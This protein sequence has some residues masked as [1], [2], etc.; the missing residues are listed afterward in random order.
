MDLRRHVG[1]AERHRLM[2]EDRFAE[3]LTL[4]RVI[5]RAFEGGARH[6]YRLRRDADAPAL[7]IGQRDLVALAFRAQP[8]RGRDAH[9]FE[10]DVAGVRRMLPQLV[11]H[12]Q[13]L[14]A[15]RVGRHD[16]RRDAALARVGVGNG[17]DDHGLSALARRDELLGAVQDVVV[18]IA[19]RA[20]AQAACV[21]SR[22]RLGQGKAADVRTAG[23]GTQELV[24]L[25]VVAE[26]QDG[27]ARDRIVHAHD[28]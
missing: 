6:P 12:A 10:G 4:A 27:H 24:L 5:S 2:I 25:R 20:R 7:Q 28:G 19:P 1:K 18:A 17:E 14:I 23:Q 16:E 22:L 26:L 21:R 9:V 11:F 3:C 13:H 8:V 15:R